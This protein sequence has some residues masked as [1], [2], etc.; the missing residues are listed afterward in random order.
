MSA[1]G[2]FISEDSFSYEDRVAALL[3]ILWNL[4]R[5]SFGCDRNAVGYTL[6]SKAHFRNAVCWRCEMRI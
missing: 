5:P 1:P 2:S 4:S 6:R 3:R